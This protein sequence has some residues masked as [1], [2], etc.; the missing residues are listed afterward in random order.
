M[1]NKEL[2]RL[3]ILQDLK[4][5][6]INTSQAAESMMVS[7]RHAYRLKN[8]L[9]KEGPEGLVSKKSWSPK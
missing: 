4:N 5:R 3:N 8:S 7:L 9:I 6:R 2:N 1:S